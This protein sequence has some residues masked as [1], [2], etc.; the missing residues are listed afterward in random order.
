M[1]ELQIGFDVYDDEGERQTKKGEI[2]IDHES[3]TIE[4]YT[5]PVKKYPKKT[6]TYKEVFDRLMKD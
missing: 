6:Y 3:A 5:A 1:P 4:V 2:W